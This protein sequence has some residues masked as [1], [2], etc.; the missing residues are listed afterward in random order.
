MW[1][2]GTFLDKRDAAALLALEAGNDAGQREIM[3]RSSS[4][5]SWPVSFIHIY[6]T[7]HFAAAV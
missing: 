3:R 6:N 2:Y 1:I 7:S 4:F 5:S